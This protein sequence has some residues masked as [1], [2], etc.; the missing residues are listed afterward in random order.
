MHRICD[1][2]HFDSHGPAEPTFG[3]RGKL[4]TSEATLRLTEV[5]D[6]VRV[7]KSYDSMIVS[8]QFRCSAPLQLDMLPGG[9]RRRANFL[10]ARRQ[11]FLA[12][13]IMVVPTLC[14]VRRRSSH[15]QPNSG[16]LPE[17]S[18]GLLCRFFADLKEDLALFGPQAIGGQLLFGIGDALSAGDVKFQ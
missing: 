14:L 12:F 4:S 16:G 8:Q 10:R 1:S 13:S 18:R 15:A 11:T 17:S 5:V 3:S 9:L 6:R 7:D 2:V